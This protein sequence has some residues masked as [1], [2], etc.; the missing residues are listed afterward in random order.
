MSGLPVRNGNE[1]A[2]Q[3]GRMSLELL[4][5]IKQFKIKHLPENEVKVRVG[6]HSGPCAA[7]VIGLKMP[8]YCLFGDTVN[9]ASRMESHGEGNIQ[10]ITFDNLLIKNYFYNSANKIHISD[11]TKHILDKFGTFHITMRGDIYLKVIDCI[12]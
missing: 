10:S 8:R 12:I 5:R 6:I 7:G 2:R 1:H 4:Y 11:T 3:I 9:V